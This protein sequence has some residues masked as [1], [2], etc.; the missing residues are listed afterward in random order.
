M[1]PK[2]PK[3]GSAVKSVAQISV[4]RP[5]GLVTPVRTW[6]TA[7]APLAPSE[8]MARMASTSRLPDMS[9]ASSIG[10]EPL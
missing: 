10:V 9:G 1:P 8:P 6:P 3:V 4:V 7:V 5:E 2:L